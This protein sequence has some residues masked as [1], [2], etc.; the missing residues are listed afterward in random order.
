LESAVYKQVNTGSSERIAYGA[1]CYFDI[2]NY[3]LQLHEIHSYCSEKISEHELK[4][5]LEEL[6]SSKKIQFH[7]GYYLLKDQSISVI[8]ERL[9]HEEYLKSKMPTIKRYAKFVSSFPFVRGVFISGS[10]SKGVLNPAGDVDYFI[11]AESGRLWL[12]RTLLIL[13]KK[14]FLFNSKKYFCVNYFVDKNSLT[15][16]DTNLFVATEIKTLV[17]VHGNETER[18]FVNANDWANKIFPNFSLN[19]E[20]LLKGFPRQFFIS[21]I[22]E[23]LCKGAVGEKADDFLFRKTLKHWRKKFPQFNESQ[24]DLNM[25]SYKSVSKHHPQGNQARVLNE[26][27]MRMNKL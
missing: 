11:I 20:P 12:C 9:E 1:I 7:K 27:A 2:F 24:F 10:V 16:P 25:R 23:K 22:I 3:P 18:G 19:K 17:P 15:V 26:L 14:L 6:L 21:M 4:L 5:A 13:F 8:S